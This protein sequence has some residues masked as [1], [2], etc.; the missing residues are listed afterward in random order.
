MTETAARTTVD[1]DGRDVKAGDEV[2]ILDVTPDPDMDED[3]ADMFVGMVGSVCE[4]DQIDEDGL[5]WVTVWW[6]TGEGTLTT[7]VGLEPQQFSRMN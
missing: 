5:A 6:N 2:R 7:T 4:I 3:D 1:R